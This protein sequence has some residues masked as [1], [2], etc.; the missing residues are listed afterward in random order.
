MTHALFMLIRVCAVFVHKMDG[1]NFTFLH[2]LTPLHWMG[3]NMSER[4]SLGRRREKIMDCL[5][6]LSFLCYYSPI[7]VVRV[8]LCDK[9]RGLL[10]K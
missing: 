1:G 8:P 9:K 7:T 5:I 10:L 2:N 4:Q 3:E 6:S